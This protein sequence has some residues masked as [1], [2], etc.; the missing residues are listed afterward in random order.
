M[1]G[2]SPGSGLTDS[3]IP[4]KPSDSVASDLRVE[5][6]LKLRNTKARLW[7]GPHVRRAGKNDLFGD[8]HFPENPTFVKREIIISRIGGALPM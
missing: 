2:C 4:A 7:G 3:R 8:D 1:L 5:E 6:S